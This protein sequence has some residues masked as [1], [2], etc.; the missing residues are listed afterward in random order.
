MDPQPC[1]S[2]IPQVY[3][4]PPENH[5]TQVMGIKRECPWSHMNQ[6]FLQAGFSLI[7][8]IALLHILIVFPQSW[9]HDAPNV[10]T[11]K[12]RK[13]LAEYQLRYAL[14]RFSIRI[15]DS[16]LWFFNAW[17]KRLWVLVLIIFRPLSV[18]FSFGANYFCSTSYN[19]GVK[20]F[21]VV[22]LMEL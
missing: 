10:Y 1:L 12:V 9:N 14:F 17:R 16:D 8:A 18:L 19:K 13:G 22:V 21:F 7:W 15:F 11:G 4:A 2:L 6:S 3:I 5:K 20:D